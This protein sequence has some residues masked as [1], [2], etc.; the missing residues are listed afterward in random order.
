M[1][2]QVERKL[3]YGML[4][5]LTKKQFHE[6]FNHLWHSYMEDALQKIYRTE[7]MKN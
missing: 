6:K 2:T 4:P 1:S 3:S 5:L 7:R